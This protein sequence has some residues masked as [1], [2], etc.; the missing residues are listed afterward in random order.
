MPASTSEWPLRY[1]VAA[2]ITRSAPSAIG[3]VRIGVAQVESTASRAPTLCAISASAF[4]SNTCHIGLD[5][6][7]AQMILVLPGRIAACTRV[8]VGHVD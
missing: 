1:L 8:E 6:V 4:K 2:C 5:G 3:C 7:S